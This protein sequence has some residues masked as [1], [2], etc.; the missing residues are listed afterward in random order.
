MKRLHESSA[1]RCLRA[2][3]TAQVQTEDFGNPGSF[4]PAAA[5]AV[6]LAIV[7]TAEK[8]PKHGGDHRGFALPGDE[9]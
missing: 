8:V 3:D 9:A 2:A 5:V 6:V 1:T 4:A 7:E